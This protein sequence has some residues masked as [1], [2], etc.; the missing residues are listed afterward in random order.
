MSIDLSPWSNSLWLMEPS[1][2]QRTAQRI[3]LF[4]T[5]YTREKIIEAK[6]LELE[7]ALA[8]C[9]DTAAGEYRRL[10]MRQLQQAI[11]RPA[12]AFDLWPL[13]LLLVGGVLAGSVAFI[14]GTMAGGCLRLATWR[15]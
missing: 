6:R 9:E 7:R 10:R 12:A 14:F 5:C 4:P 15:L 1:H 11:R 2:L 8:E 3:A 13:G